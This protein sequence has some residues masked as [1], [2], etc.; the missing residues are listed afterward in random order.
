[1]LRSSTLT[2]FIQRYTLTN[3]TTGTLAQ[4]GWFVTFGT[5]SRDLGGCTLCN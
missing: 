1:M 4:G 3:M 5:A 2:L